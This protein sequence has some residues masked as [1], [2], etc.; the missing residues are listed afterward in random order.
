MRN[1]TILWFV[2]MGTLISISARGSAET[3][4]S[5]Y[6][7]GFPESSGKSYQSRE[8]VFSISIPEHL[9]RWEIKTRNAEES[10]LAIFTSRP[11]GLPFVSSW[12][13]FRRKMPAEFKSQW[14]TPEQLLEGKVRSDKQFEQ[15]V[16]PDV[17]FVSDKLTTVVGLPAFDRIY[18]SQK[19]GATYHS[20]SVVFPDAIVTLGL[21][22]STASF[23]TDDE[24]FLTILGTLKR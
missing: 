24:E 1:R 3:E 6:Q 7:G 4:P 21:N 18:K 9:P 22:A 5:T 23:A 12:I 10:P 8:P 17:E 2:V 15:Q 16:L 13:D 20:I 11:G 19:S 14:D